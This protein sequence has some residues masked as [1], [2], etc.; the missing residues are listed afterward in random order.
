M[1]KVS[2]DAI[3]ENS[4]SKKLSQPEHRNIDN[5]NDS[6]AKSSVSDNG[7]SDDENDAANS[8]SDDGQEKDDENHIS[9]L[10]PIDLPVGQSIISAPPALLEADLEKIPRVAQV[11]LQNITMSKMF[12]FVYQNFPYHLA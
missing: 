6:L 8:S 11:T 10:S 12:R 7:N 4:A 5:V 9:G 3:A 2:L 1:S